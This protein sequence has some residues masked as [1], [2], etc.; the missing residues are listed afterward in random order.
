MESPVGANVHL[1]RTDAILRIDRIARPLRGPVYS[2]PMRIGWFPAQKISGLVQ[3]DG[4]E[5]HDQVSM[6]IRSE[7]QNIR[8][9]RTGLRHHRHGNTAIMAW[10]A[11]LIR[12]E[13]IALID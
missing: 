12:G 8:Y 11:R 9:W 5:C 3:A 13:T 4:A 10:P 2:G 6:A 7:Y 1:A